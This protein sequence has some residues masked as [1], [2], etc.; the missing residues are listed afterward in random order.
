MD[1]S[2]SGQFFNYSSSYGTGVATDAVNNIYLSSTLV[3]Q[4]AQVFGQNIN[5]TS[6]FNQYFPQGLVMKL[7]PDGNVLWSIYIQ[8]LIPDQYCAPSSLLYST[9]DNKVYLLLHGPSWQALLPDGNTMAD[10]NAAVA[11]WLLSFTAD[12]QFVEA[13]PVGDIGPSQ[14]LVEYR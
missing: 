9:F 6:T 11:G 13:K 1:P 2:G 5:T 12:G 3:A 14:L 4:K 8:S 7:N 10:F